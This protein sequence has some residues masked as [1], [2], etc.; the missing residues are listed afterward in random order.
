MTIT[1]ATAALVFFRAIQQL[2][3][4]H[5]NYTAA[6]ITPFGI[7]TAEVAMILLVVNHGWISIPWMGIGGAIGATGAMWIHTRARTR[8]LTSGEQ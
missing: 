8:R 5:G 6:A 4:V 2:N 3:V 1:I 7:A